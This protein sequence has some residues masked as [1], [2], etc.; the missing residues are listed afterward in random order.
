MT[1]SEKRKLFR[2]RW[3]QAFFSPFRR[4]K[5]GT[6]L[7]NG[8]YDADDTRMRN[9]YFVLRLLNMACIIALS[10]F[11]GVL[12]PVEAEI[13]RIDHPSEIGHLLLLWTLFVP[14]CFILCWLRCTF[15]LAAFDIDN[16]EKTAK[17]EAKDNLE[18][19]GLLQVILLIWAIMTALDWFR[20]LR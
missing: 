16:N 2:K 7:E 6:H 1:E 12:G 20:A 15:F 4:V 5:Y 10:F 13:W 9:I 8:V 19:K 14:L 17:G 11:I 18:M 3:F